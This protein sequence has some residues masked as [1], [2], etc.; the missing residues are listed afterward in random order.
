MSSIQELSKK[1]LHQ[2]G[3]FIPVPFQLSLTDTTDPLV[4]ERVV[5]IIP[6]KRAIMFGTWGKKEVVAKL[7]YDS[8]KAKAHQAR[9]KQGISILVESGILTPSLYYEGTSRDGQIYVLIFERIQGTRDHYEM[10]YNESLLRALA[11]ELATQHVSGI[12]QKDLHF[13]NFIISHDKIYVIDGGDIEKQDHPVSKEES[14][15]NLSLLAAQLGA[16]AEKSINLLLSAYGAARSWQLKQTD[17]HQVKNSIAQWQKTR[18]QKYQNKIFRDC[19]AFAVQSTIFTQTVYDRNYAN[20]ALQ[21]FIANPDK[22]FSSPNIKFLKQGRSSTVINA[23]F[24]E[25]SLVIKRYNIKNFWHG[26]RRCLRST[27]AAKSW[28][29]AQYL[30]LMKIPTAKPVAFIEKRFLGLRGKSYFIME[31]VSGM[32]LGEY[33]SKA[34]EE[35]K[36]Q[37][38]KKVTSLLE[39]LARLRL[40]HGDLKMT[41]I[42]IHNNEP[43]L[44]DLD[45]MKE[46]SCPFGFKRALKKEFAR[47]LRNWESQP[48]IYKLF[49]PMD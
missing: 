20:E 47:F 25:Q 32:H 2:G 49:V 10:N 33:F 34:S 9:D 11:I 5:R 35:Q 26:L 7:F 27:R 15:E 12:L 40:I 4:V 37:M 39:N 45:G 19:T 22:L 43:V 30:T 48:S 38:S 36:V 31:Q 16:N 21:N 8:H 46:Y 6:G 17:Y 44:I 14:L 18:W 28:R 41:N 29:L 23:A 3:R 24:Q 1:T 42:I 13:N